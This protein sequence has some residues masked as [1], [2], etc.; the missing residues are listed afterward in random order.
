[1]LGRAAAIL[2]CGL[3]L[4]GCAAAP[5]S[6]SST[7]AA[8]VANATGPRKV[9]LGPRFR[10]GP[11]GGLVARAAP[12]DG[13]SCEP[14]ARIVAVAHVEMF[15][16]GRVVVLP[17]GIGLAPPLRR[18][19]AYV[20][21]GRCVYPMRTVEPTGLVLL[22]SGSTRTLRGLFD[23]WGERLSARRVAGFRA[24][25]G[26]RVSVFI[27]GVLWR[28][29]PGSAPIAAGAQIT[30]EVGPH[31]PPHTRYTFPPL[32]SITSRS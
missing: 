15:A 7:G 9:G 31:V 28:G 22:A 8:P 27:D 21:A 12:V 20:R 14:R 4:E 30:I 18:H 2:G 26:G 24:P 17:A 19:G 10:P 5:R 13:M 25:A 29:S 6:V 11:T 3:I 23:L 1:M 32:R 16:D